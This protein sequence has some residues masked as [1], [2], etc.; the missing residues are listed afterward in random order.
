MI[1]SEHSETTQR[2]KNEAPP[3]VL[4]RFKTVWKQVEKSHDPNPENHP[5]PPAPPKKKNIIPQ[6]KILDCDNT[7][8]K[9]GPYLQ[10]LPVTLSFFYIY[11]GELWVEMTGSLRNGLQSRVCGQEQK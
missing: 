9:Q 4:Q 6:V 3:G 1:P 10:E 7:K 11:N 5:S 8:E 2:W